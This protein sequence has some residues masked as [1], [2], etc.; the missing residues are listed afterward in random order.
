MYTVVTL[1]SLII[2]AYRVCPPLPSPP[3]YFFFGVS[4]QVVEAV[5]NSAQTTPTLI[6]SWGE[7]CNVSLT[8]FVAHQ[9]VCTD[10][11][12]EFAGVS[13]AILNTLV[14]D[15]LTTLFVQSGYSDGVTSQR[16]TAVS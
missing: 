12:G 16:R 2:N 5:T 10:V 9:K 14:F 8:L 7:P 15:A 6:H 3:Q 4:T 11:F 1:Q 13:A